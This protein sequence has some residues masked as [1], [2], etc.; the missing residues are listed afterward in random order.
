MFFSALLKL[1]ALLVLGYLS[2]VDIKTRHV[3]NTWWAV[4]G[5]L[6]LTNLAL[7]FSGNTL[8]N[9]GLV[10]YY[11]FTP[12]L[13][14]FLVWDASMWG[15]ADAKAMMALSGVFYRPANYHLLGWQAPIPV[16]GLFMVSV[17]SNTLL[18]LFG[19]SA[20]KAIHARATDTDTGVDTRLPALPF[21][22][23]ALVL[24]ASVG[25]VLLILL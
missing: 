14:A 1:T 25:D 23:L 21:L 3:R 8:P 18:L 13:I 2:L 9:P 5:L 7:A 22:T 15:G 11:V 10:V 12:C 17:V 4:I 16:H 6:S 24:T 19:A 20:L